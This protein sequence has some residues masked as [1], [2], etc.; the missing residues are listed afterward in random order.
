MKKFIAILAAAWLIIGCAG[1][2]IEDLDYAD[3]ALSISCINRG[4]ECGMLAEDMFASTE[5]N[6]IE[7]W[8]NF[9][10]CLYALHD[11]GCA[12]Q[13]ARFQRVLDGALEQ[14]GE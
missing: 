6:F 14:N 3:V 7:N 9:N 1:V 8:Q 13:A 12:Q 2:Q 4:I 11:M 10:L 5:D